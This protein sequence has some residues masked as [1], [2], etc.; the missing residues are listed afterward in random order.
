M[1]VEGFFESL[2]QAFGAFIRFI[3]EALSGF[4]GILG[5]AI[6]GFIDGMSSALG[7]TPSLL[8]IAVVVIGIMLLYTAL[9]SFLRGS[10][11]SGIIWLL[12]GLWLLSA[13]IR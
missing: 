6:G 8:T 3:V 11:I 7:V 1:Y 12:L 13:L 10:I 4:F 5:N 9:R 2:G